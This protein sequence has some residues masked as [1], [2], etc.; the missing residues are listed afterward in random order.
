MPSIAKKKGANATHLAERTL[1]KIDQLRGVII[2]A[3]VQITTTRNYGDTAK[4]KSDE[5]L[6][7]M[8]LAAASVTLLI[9]LALGWRESLAWG[10]DSAPGVSATSPDRRV[11]VSTEIPRG[12]PL[13]TND[14]NYVVWRDSESGEELA[15]VFLPPV[16]SGTMVQPGYDGHMYYMGDR[17]ITKLTVRPAR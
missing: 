1:R 5:L 10:S 2:P 12:Q 3:S 7:H 16:L 11:I 9:A 4:E 6:Y 15:R 13:G 8:F 17:D 14:S